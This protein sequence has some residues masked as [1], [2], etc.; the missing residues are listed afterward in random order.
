[1]TLHPL[2]AEYFVRH[3]AADLVMSTLHDEPHFDF[4]MQVL[5]KVVRNLSAWSRSLQYRIAQALEDEELTCLGGHVEDPARYIDVTQHRSLYWEQNFWSSH[6]SFL[7][8]F[9]FQCEIEDIAVELVGIL[10]NMTVDDLP[11]G[12]QWHNLMEEYN[13]NMMQFLKR[14]LDPNDG[15]ESSCCDDLKLEVIVWLSELSADKECSCW[16]VNILDYVNRIFTQSF[17]D[18]EM[19]I[20]ILYFYEQLLLHEETRFQVIGGDGVI[21]A[22]LRCLEEGGSLGTA[23]AKCLI[24]IEDLDR[25]H[26]GSMGEEVGCYLREKRFLLAITDELDS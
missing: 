12:N 17:K 18:Y 22:I 25:N 3:C 16:L 10:N 6:V 8:S 1:M 11:A 2:C 4:T 19:S 20:E 21:D 15:N 9:T 14:I 7:W 13:S 24:L 26:D 5:I 23:A